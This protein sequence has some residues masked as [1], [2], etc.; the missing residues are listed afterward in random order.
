MKIRHD[1]LD[2]IMG[3]YQD[4]F[5]SIREGFDECMTYTIRIAP[6]TEWPGYDADDIYWWPDSSQTMIAFQLGLAMDFKIVDIRGCYDGTD[7]VTSFI[8][9]TKAGVAFDVEIIRA[10]THCYGSINFLLRGLD[11]P[12]D[13]PADVC[14]YIQQI[15]NKY[16]ILDMN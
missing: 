5:T 6:F 8:F 3:E 14:R 10:T 2:R 12:D 1:E 15:K 4:E 11:N 9:E 7:P 13:I 16:P